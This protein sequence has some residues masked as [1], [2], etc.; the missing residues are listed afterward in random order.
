MLSLELCY[1]T[2][3]VG[4]LAAWTT[5]AV[6][7]SRNVCANVDDAIGAHSERGIHPRHGAEPG[8]SG[9][10]Y[11]LQS[12]SAMR[13]GHRWCKWPQTVFKKTLPF[14]CS[15]YPKSPWKPTNLKY[16]ND[17]KVVAAMGNAWMDLPVK[18]FVVKWNRGQDFT[19]WT[20]WF[21]PP[22][23]YSAGFFGNRL[24]VR[25]M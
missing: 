19:E 17:A 4:N 2:W 16:K 7:L 22:A 23:K 24:I 8:D 10:N 12:Y 11:V 21:F 6:W 18:I 14:F 1:P 5:S 15:S 13:T 9:T 25:W 3:T 20:A